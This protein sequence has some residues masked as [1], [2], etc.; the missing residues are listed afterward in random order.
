MVGFFQPE[1]FWI[2]MWFMSNLLDSRMQPDIVCRMPEL[3]WGY[4]IQLLMRL[5]SCQHEHFEI[6][7]NFTNMF[8]EIVIQN[9]KWEYT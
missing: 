1:L 2:K 4:R 7:R 3:D 9:L 8:Y 6:K 5:V